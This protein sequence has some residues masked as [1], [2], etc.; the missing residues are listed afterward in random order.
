[1]RAKRQW[2]G[3]GLLA[4]G[5]LVPGLAWCQTSGSPG[6]SSGSA[7]AITPTAPRQRVGRIIVPDKA[8]V[9][10]ADNPLRLLR[11]GQSPLPP[12]VSDRVRTFEQYRAEYLRQQEELRRLLQGTTD[13]ERERIRQRFEEL[14][15]RWR[16]QS[17]AARQE[18]SERRQELLERLRSHRELLEKARED[19]VEIQRDRRERR[20]IDN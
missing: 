3:I 16:E 9:F 2:V 17:L 10:A 4:A 18:L 19:A 5:L 6:N 8:G 7:G 12:E 15:L 20:G 13:Q 11:P 14:R 1:M